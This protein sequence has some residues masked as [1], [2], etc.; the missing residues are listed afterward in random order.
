MTDTNL[1][2]PECLAEHPRNTAAPILLDPPRPNP[3]FVPCC[4]TECRGEWGTGCYHC[5]HPSFAKKESRMHI[6]GT[7]KP[8][9]SGATFADVK[10]NGYFAAREDQWRRRDEETGAAFRINGH[11]LL[12][13]FQPEEPVVLL[14]PPAP[15]E[16]A[17]DPDVTT[18]GELE[19]RKWFEFTGP[20]MDRGA[21][22]RVRGGHLVPTRADFVSSESQYDD[23]PVRILAPAE[24]AAHMLEAAGAPASVVV[25]RE[26]GEHTSA[27]GIHRGQPVAMLSGDFVY[28]SGDEVE[29]HE[30]D[31]GVTPER[32]EGIVRE[33]SAWLHSLAQR[34]AKS[35]ASCGRCPSDETCDC[36]CLDAEA[37]PSCLKRDAKPEP[38]EDRSK[39]EPRCSRCNGDA[40]D[41]GRFGSG[42]LCR[43]CCQAV[44]DAL[45]NYKKPDAAPGHCDETCPKLWSCPKHSDTQ[46]AEKGGKS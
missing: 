35:E 31:F 28:V 24:A 2:C 40:T 8:A 7:P 3:D 37:L 30:V 19:L 34:A 32:A 5:H 6:I 43:S 14:S 18:Y 20:R 27:G 9:P 12:G 10:A 11:P 45:N 25:H 36:A 13:T 42:P 1:A 41:G 16:P 17:P 29:A 33:L 15:R 26:P 46:Q 23:E 21:R 38:T 44:A 4:N 22:M 39:P